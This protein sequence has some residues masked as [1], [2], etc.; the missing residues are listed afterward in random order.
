MTQPILFAVGD[1]EHCPVTEGAVVGGGT[2]KDLTRIGNISEKAFDLEASKRGWLVA[3]N[4]GGAPD[5]DFIIKRP[6]MTRC[7][8]V[9]VKT[10]C[11]RINVR[12]YLIHTSS[13]NRPYSS[14][15]FDV[16]A[17]YLRETDTW[18]FYTRSELGNR[19]TTTYTPSHMRQNKQ[20]SKAPDYRPENNWKLLDEVSEL[21]TF[22]GPRTA[23][24]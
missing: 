4:S 14:T 19:I 24:V 1:G 8:V 3:I 20:P 2:K 13:R 9:Q 23:D 16:L 11:P 12:G 5:F 7:V 17:A 22:S 6:D 15:A 18:L 21:L 10:A